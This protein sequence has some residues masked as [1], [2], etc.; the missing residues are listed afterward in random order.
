[1]IIYLVMKLKI[2]FYFLEKEFF[3]LYVYFTKLDILI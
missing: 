3:I 1:M 2:S